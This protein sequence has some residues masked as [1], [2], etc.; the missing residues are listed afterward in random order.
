M[1]GKD[2]FYVTRNNNNEVR[3]VYLTSGR[4]KDYENGLIEID[5][6]KKPY[7]AYTKSFKRDVTTNWD[8][9]SHIARNQGKIVVDI[10]GDKRFPYPK[11]LYYVE[12][13]LRSI[14]ANKPNATILDFFA[15]SGTTAHAVMRLNQEDNGNRKSISVTVNSLSEKEE[16]G[17]NKKGIL[18]RDKEWQDIGIADYVTFPRLKSTITGKTAKSNYAEPIKGEYKYNRT[19]K[20]S[21]GIEANVTHYELTYNKK[22]LVENNYIYDEISPLLMM[23]SG[24]LG[25]VTDKETIDIKGYQVTK[26]HGVIADVEYVEEFAEAI[27]KQIKENNE[28]IFT[29]VFVLTN[30]N[31]QYQ[32]IA[33]RFPELK[34]EKLY[35]SYIDAIGR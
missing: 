23:K 33:K 2:Y 8:M 7:K 4:M 3:F 1:I 25:D 10:L 28:N 29:H 15:G 12:D 19:A 18:P 34:V 22:D 31:L 16:K 30:D 5:K 35:E 27:E 6:S 32:T 21:D 20:M 17:F 14:V 26:T 9:T 11:S 13:A 24:Q